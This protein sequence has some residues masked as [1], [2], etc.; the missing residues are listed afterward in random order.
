M[1]HWLMIGASALSL[2]GAFFHGVPGARIYLGN[3]NASTLEPLGKSLSAVSWHIFTIF[4]TVSGATFLAVAF[5][6][7]S[8]SAAWPLIAANA[9]GAMLFLGLSL[10]GHKAL[11]RL[12]GI[13]LMGITALCG[14]LA[15]S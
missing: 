11:L 7:A 5:D 2:F 3:I 4:L 10:R 1:D 13:Y 15:L 8:A 6:R 12:P 14:A 9:L